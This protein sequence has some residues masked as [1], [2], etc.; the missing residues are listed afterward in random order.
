MKKIIFS[1]ILFFLILILIIVISV[2]FFVKNDNKINN[3]GN[4]KSIDEIE[5]YLLNIDSYKAK[6]D[7]TVISNKN[8]NQYKMEQEVT[9]DYS[10]M[11]V[12]EPEA[13]SNMEIIYENGILQIKNTELNV[14]KV[15][16]EYPDVSK[17]VLFLTDFIKTY[18]ESDNKIIEELED[19][20]YMKVK[21]ENNKYNQ[22]QVLRINKQTLKPESLE[23]QDINNKTK[24]Y[25]LYNE[26]E[27]NI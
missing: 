25:I 1:S 14:S 27:L 7:V 9:Q 8:E 24:F 17:N 4:N 21:N 5:Q 15:Y 16:N 23:I 6:I 19:A 3:S 13:I 11:V 12:T 20:I 10:K 26:I 2:N 22:N 18:Q